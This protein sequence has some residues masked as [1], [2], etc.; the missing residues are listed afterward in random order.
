MNLNKY[1]IPFCFKEKKKFK[2]FEYPILKD[3]HFWKFPKK[4]NSNKNKVLI[5]SGPARNGNHLLL[6]LLD[7]HP[8]IAYH[9]GEDSFL[10]SIFS[11]AKK[12]ELNLINKL[13]KADKEFILGLSG[14]YYDKEAK[15]IFLKNKWLHLSQQNSKKKLKIWSG[16]QKENESFI[17]DYKDF[18]PKINYKKFEKN[19]LKKNKFNNFFDFFYKYLES[20][21]YLSNNN[22]KKKYRYIWFSSGARRELF[23]LLN[24]TKNIRVL[25]P[26][27]EFGGFYNSFIKSK[28]KTTKFKKKYLHEAWEHWYHK[29]IDFLIL[30]KK[31]PKIFFIIKFED[32]VNDTEFTMKKITKKLNIKLSDKNLKSSILNKFVKGNSSFVRKSK[33]G[34]IYKNKNEE[35]K[36]K[37]YLPNEYWGILNYLN[38]IKL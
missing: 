29:V 1:K 34:D 12:N 13:K 16:I 32:L 10:N 4:Y 37:E 17:I 20:I 23:F 25:S 33:L 38:K 9:I 15:K 28:Y 36:Y 14:Q 27:R 30:Q 21:F 8:E 11:H 19:I 18:I 7:G 24:K 26:I 6:S 22:I 2:I 31:Y 35:F 5:I 3:K